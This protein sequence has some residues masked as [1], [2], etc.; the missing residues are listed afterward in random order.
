M[1]L[2]IYVMKWMSLVFSGLPLLHMPHPEL[3]LVFYMKSGFTSCE[4]SSS[5]RDV[6]PKPKD[7]VPLLPAHTY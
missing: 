7:Q 2:V 3:A 6:Y 4:N 5:T 1:Y